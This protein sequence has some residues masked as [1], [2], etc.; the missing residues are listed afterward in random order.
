VPDLV[1]L[2]AGPQPDILTEPPLLI[3]EIL[4]PNDSYSDT[5]ER[6][7]DYR[8]MGVE[9]VWIIDPKT[10]SGRMCSGSEWVESTRLEVKRTPLY[11]NLPDIF[12]QLTSA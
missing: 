12:S 10:R 2:I 5:Q 9:T 11:V 6:A 4:S 3:I 7:R 8:A 1:V